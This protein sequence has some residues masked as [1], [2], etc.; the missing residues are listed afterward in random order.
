M[1]EFDVVASAFD[2]HRAQPEGLAVSI[3]DAVW[4]VAGVGSGRV[5]DVGAGTG[6][7]GG[8]FH[9]AGDGYVGV[10]PSRGMLDR[11]VA[12]A[13]ADHGRRPSLIQAD[14][15]ALPFAAGVFDA[16]LLVQVLSGLS[17]WRQVLDEARR[18]LRPKACLAIGRTILS[19]DGVD[20]RM[21]D[22]LITILADLDIRAGRPGA[23]AAEAAGW[24]A[25]QAHR[26][27]HLT[28][29]EWERTGTPADFLDRHRTGA[30]F[31]AL[32]K[33][34]QGAALARLEA[35][36][37]STIGALDRSIVEHRKFELD[38]FTFREAW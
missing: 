4:R 14:G 26:H 20:R 18:V 19:P 30:R 22:Q 34:V 28:V 32:P 9:A 31:A 10:D 16:V 35:W 12:R 37:R 8:A 25:P 13:D 17:A 3:R 5:L 24:L 27:T 7:V 11:F 15:C 38:V 23:S 2:A 1:T 6:R 21:R 29:G 36:T 33:P